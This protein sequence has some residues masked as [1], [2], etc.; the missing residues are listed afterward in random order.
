MLPTSTTPHTVRSRR[1]ASTS[2]ECGSG[3][4]HGPGG[5]R[6]TRRPSSTSSDRLGGQGDGEPEPKTNEEAV[7]MACHPYNPRL[8]DILYCKISGEWL[9]L[10]KPTVDEILAVSGAIDAWGEQLAG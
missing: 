7:K 8:E 10:K 6:P 1:P 2:V 9:R 5:L 3:V 4:S